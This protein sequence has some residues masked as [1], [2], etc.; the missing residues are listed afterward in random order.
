VTPPAPR[1]SRRYLA[2]PNTQIPPTVSRRCRRD[3]GQ[4]FRWRAKDLSRDPWAALLR[5]GTQ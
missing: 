1:R 2:P 3:V 4:D 5:D